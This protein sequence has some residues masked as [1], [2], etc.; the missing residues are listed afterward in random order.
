MGAPLP[1]GTAYGSWVKD[2]RVG[3][4]PPFGYWDPLGLSV[5]S[6]EGQKAY[7]R[8]AELK[9]GRTC[10][11][12]SLGFVVAERFHP[13]FGRDDPL[14]ACVLVRLP[15]SRSSLDSEGAKGQMISV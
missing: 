4:F 15:G 2:D 5:G 6:S 9:H 10:M 13:F 8:E 11:L 7:L 1:Q 3:A 12:A 14:L